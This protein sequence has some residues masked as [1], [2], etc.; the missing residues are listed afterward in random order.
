M[1]S[2]FEQR[3]IALENLEIARSKRET[4]ALYMMAHGIYAD[5]VDDHLAI[6][7]SHSTSSL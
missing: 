2:L 1:I 7:K 6:G 5:L 3:R 4:A